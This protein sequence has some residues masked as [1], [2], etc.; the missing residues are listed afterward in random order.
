MFRLYT[1]PKA[2]ENELSSLIFQV[3]LTGEHGTLV[4]LKPALSKN[5]DSKIVQWIRKGFP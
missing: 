4:Y 1:L 2:C 3:T 5:A